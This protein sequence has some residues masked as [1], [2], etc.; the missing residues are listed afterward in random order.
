[1]ETQ[2]YTTQITVNTSPSKV[3]EAVNNVKE[4][5]SGELTGPTQAIGD[6]FTY[7]VGEVHFSRQKITELIPNQK[8]TW[9]VTDSRLNFTTIPDEWTNTTICFEIETIGSHTQLTFTHKGLTPK[10]ECYDGC[11]NAWQRL[12]HESLFSLIT[13]GK[14][15]KIF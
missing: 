9:L 15:V 5:W 7:Q 13:T 4:W 11:S 10:F 6:E 14:G 12:I 2:D 3:F 8:I 1:M